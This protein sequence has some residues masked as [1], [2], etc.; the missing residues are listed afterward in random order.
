MTSAQ[1]HVIGSGPAGL[2][3]ASA[4]CERGYEVTVVSDSPGSFSLWSGDFSFGRELDSPQ[5]FPAKWTDARWK[6]AFGDLA[7]LFKSFGV[8]LILPASEGGIPHTVTATGNLRPTF[9]TP[10][11][12]YASSR[13]QDIVIVGM[14]GLAD[15]LVRAQAASYRSHTGARAIECFIKRPAGWNQ[16]WGSIRYASYLETPEGLGWLSRQLAETLRGAPSNVPVL[17]P[18]VLGFDGAE[19]IIQVLSGEL[20][21]MVAEFPLVSPSVGGIRIRERWER[22]LRRRRVRFLSG[23][24]NRVTPEGRVAL[25]DGRSLESDYVVLATG[26]ILGGGLTVE[27]NGVVLDELANREVGVIRRLSDIDDIGYLDADCLGGARVLAVGRQLGGWNPN[28]D[29]N[30]GAMVLATVYDAVRAIEGV[31]NETV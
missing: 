15:S 16:S 14:D 29:H 27:M 4:L 31:E 7:V 1:V 9:A 21:R 26:G 28:R 25:V 18:Q 19:Q 20:G 3:A 12:Q 17:I 13:V 6:Q 10:S 23:H 24:V 22:D 2:L 11:W 5:H 30:G 8:D